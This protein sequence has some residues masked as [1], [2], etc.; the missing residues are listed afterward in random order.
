TLALLVAEREPRIKACAAFAAVTDVEAR[1]MT[2]APG[3]TTSIPGY[4]EFLRHRS[5][6]T[7]AAKLKCPLFL[8]HANDDRN[9]FVRETTDFAVL[10][11]KTNPN[12]KLVIV[13]RGG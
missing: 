3:I 11:K 8:F 6:K 7:H 4:R 2:V 13:P 9:V 1:I 12:V 5:P 10:V